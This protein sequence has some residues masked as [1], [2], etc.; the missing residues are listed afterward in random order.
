MFNIRMTNEYHILILEKHARNTIKMNISNTRC[1][2][3]ENKSTYSG[4]LEII[5][6]VAA[7]SVVCVR[8]QDALTVGSD[9]ETRYYSSLKVLFTDF[10]RG[11]HGTGF[12]LLLYYLI[13]FAYIY[14]KSLWPLR[15]ILRW[16]VQSNALL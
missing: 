10:T 1:P 13:R 4:Y 5:E 11:V 2:L 8:R 14:S 3:W 15:L 16:P 6:V 7:E 12:S 9:N